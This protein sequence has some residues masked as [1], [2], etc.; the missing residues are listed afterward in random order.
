MKKNWRKPGKRRSART[1]QGAAAGR[2][3]PKRSEER[4]RV[5]RVEKHQRTRIAPGR[6][7]AT[8]PLLRKPP[9]AARP[10]SVERNAH[11]R[12]ASR[13]R[14]VARARKRV[15][16]KKKVSGASVRTT[17]ENTKPAGDARYRIAAV[18]PAVG[19]QRPAVPARSTRTVPKPKRR[20]GNRA[21]HGVS[22]K[23]RRDAALT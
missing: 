7:T 22:P 15:A 13:R 8:S 18:R 4:W 16:V 3:G 17:R 21:A 10:V 2:A 20:V 6:T 14:I 11:G 19:P 12:R 23:R 9:A 5:R 1:N